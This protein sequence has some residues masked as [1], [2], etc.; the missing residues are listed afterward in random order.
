MITAATPFYGESGGQVGD[1][2][3]ISGDGWRIRVTDTQRLP[4]DLYRPPGDGGGRD[5]QGQRRGPPGGGRR[6]APAHLPGT[7]PPPISSR[8]C[9]GGIWAST[10][11]SPARWLTPERLRFDFTHF[12]AIS[13][14]E[15]EGS[16]WT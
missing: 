9:C 8:R 7:T 15:V 10:S 12:Q 13:P 16:S 5:G 6:P 2:G 1:T 14:E 3:V 11:S 4:N